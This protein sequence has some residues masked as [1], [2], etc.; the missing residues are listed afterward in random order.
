MIINNTKKLVSIA[1]ILTSSA[2]CSV[3]AADF[4]RGTAS[5]T[6]ECS[7]FVTKTT[8]NEQFTISDSGATVTDNITG[9]TWSSCALG[10]TWDKEQGTCT[11][12]ATVATWSLALNSAELQSI[13]GLNNWRL[14]NIKEL[15]TTLERSC[16]YPSINTYLFPSINVFNY[17]S[18]T[19]N[20]TASGGVFTS[21]NSKSAYMLGLY[22]GVIQRQDKSTTSHVR[23]VHD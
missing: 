5:A 21:E 19:P 18:S 15:A 2:T 9:L 14:P 3:Y 22:S 6:Q 16:T 10:E 11:G 13:D 1:I 23:Y 8:P 17:W 7:P 4:D 12:E 20:N